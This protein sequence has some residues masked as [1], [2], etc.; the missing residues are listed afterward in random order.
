MA[1][2]FHQSTE[3]SVPSSIRYS[4]VI[5]TYNRAETLLSTLQS[6]SEVRLLQETEVIVVDNN[7]SDNTK[8]VV[9]Q[10]M[11]WFP[12]RLRYV[13]EVEQGRS[14]ALNSGIRLCRGDIILITDDDVR[15]D[16]DWISAA[17]RGLA[18]A[19]CDYVCGKALPI[20]EKERPRWLPNRG[21]KHWA[22]VGLLDYGTEMIQLGAQV[23]L[24]LNMAF[25]RNAFALA[26]MWNN[27]VGR[28]GISLLGQEVREWGLRARAVGLTGFYI[29]DMVVHHLI[30]A[31]RLNKKYFRR[32]FY[33][34]GISRAILFELRGVDMETPEETTLDFS[35]VPQIAGVPRYM[36]R[37]FLQQIKNMLSSAMRRDVVATFEYELW[38]WFFAGVLAQRWKDRQKKFGFTSSTIQG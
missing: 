8:D 6:L 11:A 23:P 1:L 31:D 30:P 26:G 15:L 27:L 33:W 13:F 21:G 18:E 22:V 36:Y 29:P 38:L 7:S 20:W 19:N 4:V 34:H 16:T 32:W 10:A 3:G 37:S 24:G 12:E 28:R 9:E 14:A 25:R 5:P 35:K 17:E 2:G